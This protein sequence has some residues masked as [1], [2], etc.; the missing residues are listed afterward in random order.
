MK[1]SKVLCLALVIVCAANALAVDPEVPWVSVKSFGAVGDGVTDDTAA[2]QQAIDYIDVAGNY[3]KNTLF[4]PSG[5]YLV[6]STLVLPANCKML[7]AGVWNSVDHP[8]GSTILGKHTGAAVVSLVGK[9]YSQ[10]ENLHIFGDST[11]TPQTGLLLGRSS[12]G[13]AGCHLIKNVTVSGYYSKAAIYSIA[14]EQNTY[15]NIV[16]IVEGGT[17]KYV[18]FTSQSDDLSVGGLTGSSNMTGQLYGSFFWHIIDRADASVIFMDVGGDTGNWTFQDSYLAT[19]TSHGSYV[20]IRVGEVDGQSCSA[21]IIFDRVDGEFWGG[22]VG[23]D[24]AYHI[25]GNG[26]TLNGL[27]ITG[28]NLSA[29]SS[30]IYC[31]NAELDS[32]EITATSP[33][34][35]STFWRLKNSNINLGTQNITITSDAVNNII[36]HT[37]ALTISGTD[38]GNLLRSPNAVGVSGRESIDKFL[39]LQKYWLYG[40]SAPASGTWARGDIVWNSAPSIG[41]NIGWICVVGGTP[42]TWTTLG[43]ID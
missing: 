17:A 25:Q 28:G 15:I 7:G 1:V 38:A 39:M 9:N 31:D 21:P 10:I 20:T 33:S 36:R 40:T 2:I 8:L 42:G 6:T 30:F 3:G 13:S 29:N 11:V 37:G 12:P 35:P 41:G 16:G 5:K 22:S 26:Q 27:V 19:A 14:S 18:F 43:E 34:K 23:P 32:A 24:K 4:F